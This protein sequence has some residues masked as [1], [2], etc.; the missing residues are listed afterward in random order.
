MGFDLKNMNKKKVC[1]ISVLVVLI[2]VLVGAICYE[3]YHIKQLKAERER[4]RQERLAQEQP[5]PD[6]KP[7]DYKV[8]KDFND[9]LC[10]KVGINYKNRYEKER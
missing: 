6:K 7:S 3:N 4:V 10:F 9:F 5:Q 1:A 8:G 2:G